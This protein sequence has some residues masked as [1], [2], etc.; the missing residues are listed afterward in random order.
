MIYI[1]ADLVTDL[2]IIKYRDFTL[3]LDQFFKFFTFLYRVNEKQSIL[4]F[5]Y[6]SKSAVATNS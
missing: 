3:K 6:I 2:I 4:T 5:C 1:A